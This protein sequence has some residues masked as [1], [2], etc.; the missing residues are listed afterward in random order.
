[1]R[2]PYCHEYESRVVDSRSSEDN[3]FIRRRRE[4]NACKRRFTTYERLEERVLMV[5]KKGGSREQFYRDK[6]L[7]GIARAC[8]KRPVSME[9]I[10][11][12][13]AQIE[14]DLRDNF[15]HEVSSKIIGEKVMDKLQSIDEVAYVRFASV[16]RQFTDLNSFIRTIEQLKQR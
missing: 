5:V 10:E 8:E 11:N 2:C 3:S 14:R 4:C 16:Y 15:D 9:D 7:N 1:M 12:V 13:V 6:I